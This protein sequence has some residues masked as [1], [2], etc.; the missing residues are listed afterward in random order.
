MA[1][2]HLHPP[3][4]SQYPSGLHCTYPELLWSSRVQ[5]LRAKTIHLQIKRSL[6]NLQTQGAAYC[7]TLCLIRW[8][9]AC[10]VQLLTHHTVRVQALREVE[11]QRAREKLKDDSSTDVHYL[12]NVILK[13]FE[14]GAPPLLFAAC[15]YSFGQELTDSFAVGVILTPSLLTI[16]HY[17]SST[18]FCKEHSI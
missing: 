8:R 3:H 10:E 9:Y 16:A 18:G 1:P 14:T 2:W 5:Y 15:P 12:K 6:L 13:M 4:T 17:S 7:Y 11:R